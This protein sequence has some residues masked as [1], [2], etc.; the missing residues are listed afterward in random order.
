MQEHSLQWFMQILNKLQATI[1]NRLQ[2]SD[3]KYSISL[4]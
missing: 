2:K 3:Y 4:R 1:L